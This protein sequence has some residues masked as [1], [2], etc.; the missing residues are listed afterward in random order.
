ML[1]NNVIF[2]IDAYLGNNYLLLITPHHL[3]ARHIFF[4][5]M[6][7]LTSGAGGG[8]NCDIF[9]PEVT[10]QRQYHQ[11]IPIDQLCR[12]VVRVTSVLVISGDFVLYLRLLYKKVME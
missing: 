5:P 2:L 10:H 4:K 1:C 8:G 7:I 11:L 6:F 9:M 12:L 3:G